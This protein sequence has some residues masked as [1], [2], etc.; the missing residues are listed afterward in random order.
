VKVPEPRAGAP[1]GQT[2]DDRLGEILDAQR[3]S[4]EAKV[5]RPRERGSDLLMEAFGISPVQLQSHSQ[6]W[7]RQLG[8][9]FER[10][11][12]AAC[13]HR[14]ECRL[15]LR[16]G[17]REPWDLEFG[18]E[19]WELKYRLGSGDAGTL[20][21]LADNAGLARE[22]G[23]APVLLI[24][25]S[26]SLRAATARAAAGGWEVVCGE[27]ALAHVRRRSGFDLHAW[28]AEQAGRFT[29]E[30]GRREPGSE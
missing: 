26:D 6:Y 29:F 17:G 7:S 3:R 12:R 15:P 11:V 27:R 1:H 4:F 9:C 20:S 14:S 18:Q 23:L 21:R 28:L 16:T 25:R 5:H 30:P 24:L 13:E 2:V 10:L 8:M 19:A 22:R